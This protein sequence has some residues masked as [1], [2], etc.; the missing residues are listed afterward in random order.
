MVFHLS[1][2]IYLLQHQGLGVLV[3]KALK[4]QIF[5]LGVHSIKYFATPVVLNFILKELIT[6]MNNDIP[7]EYIHRCNR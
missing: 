2:F 5:H 7:S 3:L 6:L 1:G 4:F